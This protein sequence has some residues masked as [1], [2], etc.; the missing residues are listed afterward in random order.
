MCDSPSATEDRLGDLLQHVDVEALD[1]VGQGVAC[2]EQQRVGGDTDDQLA[3]VMDRRH[4]RAGRQ[5]RLATATPLAAR[6]NESHPAPSV[7]RCTL[8][9]SRPPR[10]S[11]VALRPRWR[12]TDERIPSSRRRELQRSRPQP[13]PDGRSSIFLQPLPAA[14]RCEHR[15]DQSGEERD[16]SKRVQRIH[17]TVESCRRG[18]AFRGRDLADGLIETVERTRRIDPC[19]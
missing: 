13:M 18:G 5:L 19:R 2:A 15:N 10:W 1:L 4:R 7:Q 8:V 6:T 16:V 9:A 14:E 3:P 11:S 12:P 17:S